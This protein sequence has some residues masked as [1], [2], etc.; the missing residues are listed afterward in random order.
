[1]NS[2]VS[3]LCDFFERELP[4]LPASYQWKIPV[5]DGFTQSGESGYRANVELKR[6]LHQRWNLATYERK[7]D[8]V[9]VIVS[10]WG[11]VRANKAET[12]KRYVDAIAELEPD[13]PLNGVASYSKI[14]SIV[15]PEQYAIY[16]ARV[17]ACLNAV[18]FNAGIENGIAFNYVPGRNNVIGNAGKKSGFTQ[19]PE[20]SVKSLTN[21]GW[22][23]LKRNDTYAK[24]NQVLS[25]CLARLPSRSRFELEMVLFARAEHECQIAMNGSE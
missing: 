21:S 4:C 17:A 16:D 7:L 9:E 8:L 3:V 18:Q 15:R 12:L 22:L 14:F 23:R 13:T 11:G 25:H 24:Y 6:H 2:L 19:L 5:I 1:M 20:F 10:D